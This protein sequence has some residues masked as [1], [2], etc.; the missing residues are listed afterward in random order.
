MNQIPLFQVF[1]KMAFNPKDV[2]LTPELIALEI[3]RYFKPS[4][5]CLEPCKGS[6]SFLKHLP[7]DSEWCEIREGRD[8]FEYHNHVDWIVSN[9]PYSIFYE[10]LR[11]SFEIADNIVYLV[12]LYKV[13]QSIKYLELIDDFGGIKTIYLVGTGRKCKLPVGFAMGAVYF[14]RGYKEGTNWV[15]RMPNKSLNTDQKQRGENSEAN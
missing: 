4:G 6:G 15:V 3:V 7:K 9:P 14:K 11:H 10:W 1:Q 2:W 8:F 13:V 5:K 12:P